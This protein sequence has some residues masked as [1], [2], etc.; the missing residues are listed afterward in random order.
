[1]TQR[2]GSVE[3]QGDRELRFTRFSPVAFS[4]DQLHSQPIFNG[5]RQRC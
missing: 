3:R 1:M 4:R 5:F 2:Q